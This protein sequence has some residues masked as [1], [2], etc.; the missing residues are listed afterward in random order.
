MNSAS[1]C[2]GGGRVPP[3]GPWPA[4]GPGCAGLRC[5]SVL[6][7]APDYPSA[8]LTPREAS[9]ALRQRPSRW[10]W[11]LLLLAAWS[12]P[13]SGQDLPLRWHHAVPGPTTFS[14][15]RATDLDGDGI[16]DLVLG[17]GREG[18]PD[19]AGIFAFSGATGQP[20]WQRYARDQVYGSPLFQDITGD[21]VPE[22]FIGGRDAQFY[23]LDGA[24]GFLIWE[25]WPDSWGSA[26]DAGWYN[27][28]LPQWIP[29]QDGDGYRDLILT[30]GG[31]PTLAPSV[32]DRPPGYL[33]ALSARDGRV[34]QRDTMPDGQETYHSPLVVD[35][36]GQGRLHL[37]FGSGGETTGGSY[38]RVALDSFMTSGLRSAQALLTHPGKGYIAVP[39]LADLNHDQR[40]DLII[41]QMKEAIIALDGPSG[42]EIWRVDLPGAECYVSPTLGQFTGDPTPDAFVITSLGNWPF[43]QQGLKLLIDGATGAVVWTESGFPFQLTSGHAYDP[44][45]DG[46]DE[47][48]YPNGADTA[49][50]GRYYQHQFYRYDF[51]DSTIIPLDSPRPGLVVFSMP[52]LTDLDGDGQG[53]LIVAT[54]DHTGDWYQPAGF[55]L[56][57]FDLGP[58]AGL[59][60]WGGYQGSTG[61]GVYA[62][63]LSLDID[64][65]ASMPLHWRVYP[66][67]VRET[68]WATL[69]DGQAPEGLRL[70]DLQGRVLRQTQHH[71]SLSVA[72]L[73]AG[74]YLLEGWLGTRRALARVVVY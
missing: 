44:D 10:G 33:L 73:P 47:V 2:R 41:P 9:A 16:A 68:L 34:L 18:Q 56:W 50:T 21:G 37:C 54:H 61:N 3:A 57:R 64:P 27:F 69:D 1:S 7:F 5:A 25:F 29:D 28:Y 11:L 12:G 22:V 71:N 31:D 30:N 42:Q 14:S 51:N 70:C 55:S 19:P 20:L 62:L 36:G 40:P 67:P 63:H 32:R 43:Y 65:V 39:S 17:A 48:L 23:A 72:G 38:W 60:A 49:A 45:G 15:P 46:Y 13:L 24:T 6:R 66:N 58:L 74:V 35:F 53:D 52:L 59:P 26:L 4:G 8:S